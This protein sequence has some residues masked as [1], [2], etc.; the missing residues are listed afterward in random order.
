[1]SAGQ[2]TSASLSPA[3]DYWRD[4]ARPL[5]SLAFV[6]PFLVLYEGGAAL[7][8][9]NAA[10]NGADLWLRRL[11]DLAGFSQYFLLPLLTCGLLLAWHHARREPWRIGGRVVGAMWLEAA[12]WG[13]G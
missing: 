2:L 9:S 13:A 12:A 11:L 5:V 3:H 6:A 1:M 10:R 8:G 4:S 7:V